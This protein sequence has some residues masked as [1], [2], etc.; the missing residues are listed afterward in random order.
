MDK[1]EL[2]IHTQKTV[3]SWT[4]NEVDDFFHSELRALSIQLSDPDLQPFLIKGEI[5]SEE[6]ICGI[7]GIYDQAIIQLLQG[8]ITSI[9]EIKFSQLSTKRKYVTDID[10]ILTIGSLV[11][12][13]TDDFIKISGCYI[14]GNIDRLYNL[15]SYFAGLP[16]ISKTKFKDYMIDD[17]LYALNDVKRMGF[18]D[19]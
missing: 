16:D 7:Y 5:P 10:T 9:H 14:G 17:Y 13:E 2:F 3:P 1:Y 19:I 6:K 15:A 12:L 4:I 11:I 8:K 18:F